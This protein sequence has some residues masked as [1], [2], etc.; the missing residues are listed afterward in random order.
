MCGLGWDKVIKR[1]RLCPGYYCRY[2]MEWS[3]GGAG[4]YRDPANLCTYIHM[5]GNKKHLVMYVFETPSI[6]PDSLSYY[7]E[8]VATYVDRDLKSELCNFSSCVCIYLYIYCHTSCH[9]IHCASP[10]S[11]RKK[12]PPA[13]WRDAA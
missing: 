12:R 7:W 13:V 2:C 6:K 8:G 5:S 3:R 1:H 10:C 11:G 9:I 4:S